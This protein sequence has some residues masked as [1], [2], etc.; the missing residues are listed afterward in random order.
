MRA[1]AHIIFFF[2][3]NRPQ[4]PSKFS[5]SSAKSF[6]E[7]KK[8]LLGFWRQT[9]ALSYLSTPN[10]SGS[11]VLGNSDGAWGVEMLQDISHTNLLHSLECLQLSSETHIPRNIRGKQSMCELKCC[12]FLQLFVRLFHKRT[13]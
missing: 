10:Q 13:K 12:T 6:A 8:N 7:E 9:K 2:L 5:F 3:G 11:V 1:G 4:N